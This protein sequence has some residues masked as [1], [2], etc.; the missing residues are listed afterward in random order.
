MIKYKMWNRYVGRTRIP[1]PDSFVDKVEI[2]FYDDNYQ[3]RGKIITTNEYAK[4]LLI[5]W[6]SPANLYYNTGG[7]MGR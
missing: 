1:L 2:I 6:I 7:T 5:E 4:S 3:N